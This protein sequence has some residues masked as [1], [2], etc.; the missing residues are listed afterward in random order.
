MTVAAIIPAKA[1]SAR[2]PRKN[3]RDFHGQPVI[4]YSIKA[5]LDSRLFDN[6]VVS[7]DSEEVSEVAQKYGADVMMRGEKWCGDDVGP[8]DVARH[9]LSLM[10]QDVSMVCVLYAAAPL[11]RVADLVQGYYVACR[12]GMAY[13]VSVGDSPFLHDA[14]QFFWA[15]AWALRERKPEFA[16]AT[17]LV[18]VPPERDCDINTE[19]DWLRAERLYAAVHGCQHD[20]AWMPQAHA[21]ASF[22]QCRKCGE[23]LP[24]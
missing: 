7:T 2:V 10:A 6:V 11:M 21:D 15:H 14:A 19:E 12:P 17:G 20:F 1:H 9:S 22:F 5:A 16:D 4:A 13:A 23:R 18:R 3:W 8:L 24:T